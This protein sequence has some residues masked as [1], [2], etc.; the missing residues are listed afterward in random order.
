MTTDAPEVE[1]PEQDLLPGEMTLLEHLLE[2]RKRVTWMA[3]AVLVGMVLFFIPKIGFGAIEFLLE[4]AES[5]NPGFRTQA[6]T[7]LENIVTYFRV[8]CWAASRSACRC[9]STRRCGSCTRRWR[10]ARSA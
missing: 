6:I 10:P 9:S 2:V 8:A 1:S 3:A 4:P 7:P 5:R